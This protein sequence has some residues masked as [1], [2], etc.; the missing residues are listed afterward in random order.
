[1]DSTI[2]NAISNLKAELDQ[3]SPMNNTKIQETL[4]IEYIN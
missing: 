3:F 2:F 1:M 4:D